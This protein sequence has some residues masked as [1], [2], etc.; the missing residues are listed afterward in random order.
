MVRL[1]LLVFIFAN[2][3]NEFEGSGVKAVLSGGIEFINQ[4]ERG[5]F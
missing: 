1:F 2:N 4:Q 3:F 5:F